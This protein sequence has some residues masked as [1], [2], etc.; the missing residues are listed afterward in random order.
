MDSYTPT[1]NQIPQVQ[2][3]EFLPQI[4]SW[5]TIGGGFLVVLFAC[6]VTASSVLEYRVAVKTSATIRPAGEL[7][8]VQTAIDGK[9]QEIKVSKNQAVKL[10]QI[11]ASIDD[12]R[13]RTRKEQL[14]DS[15]EESRLQIGQMNAQIRE[16]RV[17]MHAQE[18]LMEHNVSVAQADLQKN[19]R[20]YQD[21]KNITNADL[22]QAKISEQ[23]AQLKLTRL[24]KEK[25]LQATIE[26]AKA[27]FRLAKAQRDRMLPILKEGAIS[28]NYFEEKEQAVKAAQA[29]LEQA[30][31]S[32]KTLLAETEEALNI[33]QINLIRAQTAV[34]PSNANILISRQGIQQAKV[35]GEA[36]LAALNK[37]LQTLFISRLELEKKL[38]RDMRELK[39][40]E[41]DLALTIIRAPVAGTVLELNLRNPQQ[42]LRS[43][44]VIANIAPSDAPLRIKAKVAAQD[45][46]KV[47]PQQKVQM[48]VSAC[49]YP[50]FGTLKGKVETIAPDA[51][52]NTSNDNGNSSIGATYEVTIIP[53][54]LYVGEGA[55]QC[56][57]LP[58]MEGK[59]SIISR[60]ETILKFILRK[61]RLISSF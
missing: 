55:N 61:A 9:V 25:A 13:L 7:R 5:L 57:L 11:I 19:E 22:E 49:P 45:I 42:V 24:Q 26:E 48:Q 53:E 31:S 36:T 38:Q 16:L 1:S 32:A 50:D 47:R 8:L 52:P 28:R 29:K 3:N 34:N 46:D 20:L 15:I 43:G 14:K 23:F 2:E 10:G 21:R 39:Q 51:L 33:A 35:R 60:E 18:S 58:G 37:E 41:K 40:V 30:K 6:G 59:A 4:S 54:A 12:F 44:E 17:Q 27:S 56:T